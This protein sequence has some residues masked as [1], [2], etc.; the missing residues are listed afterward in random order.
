LGYYILEDNISDLSVA[1]QQ[2]VYFIALAK[3]FGLG[4]YLTNGDDGGYGNTKNITQE[5]RDKLRQSMLGNK[6]NAGKKHSPERI[7]KQRL[8]LKGI[9]RSKESI[10]KAKITRTLNKKAGKVSRHLSRRLFS[11][12]QIVD[13][14]HMWNALD[15]SAE[16]IGIKYGVGYATISSV[17]NSKTTYYE[18][19]KKYDLV[20]KQKPIL[21]LKHPACRDKYLAILNQGVIGREKRAVAEFNR[22]QINIGQEYERQWDMLYEIYC[23]RLTTSVAKIANIFK[24]DPETIRRL[25]LGRSWAEDKLFLVEK[26]YSNRINLDIA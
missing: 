13:I 16:Q 12:E 4:T 22:V 15:Q 20:K 3:K 10:E 17:L 14:F 7:E 21:G 18:I 5:T 1:L 6:R 8:S 19:K 23:L 25:L 11:E 24:K 9:V 26:A 2:E